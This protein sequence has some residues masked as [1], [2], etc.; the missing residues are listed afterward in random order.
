[1]EEN[2]SVGFDDA[3]ERF[4]KELSLLE[5]KAIFESDTVHPMPST[6][7]EKV[8]RFTDE[9]NELQANTARKKLKS[10]KK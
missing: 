6:V 9:L 4:E 10:W 8:V 5:D 7:T 2:N 3:K 1:M